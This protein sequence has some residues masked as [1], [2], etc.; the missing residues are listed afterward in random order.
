MN[1]GFQITLG[2]AAAAALAAAAV[3]LFEAERPPMDTVQHGYRGTAMDQIYNPR[4]VDAL[5]ADNKIPGSLPRLPDVG[6]KAGTVYKNVQVLKDVSVGNFTRLMASITT[7]VAPVQG[8][9]YCHNVNNMADDGLYTKVVARRMIQMVQHINADWKDHVAATGVTCYTCHRGNP[10]PVN[11]WFNN[12][13]PVQAGGFAQTPSGRAHP[14]PV[15]GNSSL[16]YDPFTPYLEQ[17]T[18]IRI[19]STQ[20]LP[21]TDRQSINQTEWTYALMMNFSQSLGV[22]CTYCHNTRSFSDWSQSSPQRV[23]AWYGIR[24]VRDINNNYLDPLHTVFP[25]A[26]LGVEGDSAKVACATCHNG[27][28]KPLFGVSMVKDFPE[29]QT[30]P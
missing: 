26:R 25:T 21:G 15:A 11:I 19:A 29:L 12:P 7:W 6:G 27:V 10:V 8:C 28:Y 17:D 23:T 24:M 2:G 3:I 1:L 5:R 30:H 20:A 18:E 16:P 9:A 22:N 13:G 4:F 14:T